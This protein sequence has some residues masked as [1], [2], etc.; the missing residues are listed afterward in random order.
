MCHTA[1]LG[2][3]DGAQVADGFLQIV[4]DDDIIETIRIFQLLLGGRQTGGDLFLRFSAAA[5]QAVASLRSDFRNFRR[6]GVL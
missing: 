6:A 4:V 1:A 3:Q 2:A 5:V